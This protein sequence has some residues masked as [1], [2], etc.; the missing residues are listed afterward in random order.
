MPVPVR[1]AKQRALLA[2][3]R[4]SGSAR[5]ADRRAVV[6]WIFTVASLRCSR[7]ARS[8]RSGQL[9]V[10]LGGRTVGLGQKSSIG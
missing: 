5:P 9:P 4:G 8:G 1:S 3:Q 10:R 6:G 7:S 2:L